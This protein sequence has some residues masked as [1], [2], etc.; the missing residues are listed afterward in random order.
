MKKQIS[1]D[2]LY[3]GVVVGCASYDSCSER[4]KLEVRN[5]FSFP[6]VKG[7]VAKWVTMSEEDRKRIEDPIFYMFCDVWGRCEYEFVVCPW[8]YNDED[9][10]DGCGV[11]VDTYRM[12]VEPNKDLLLDMVSRVTKSS[13]QAYL[14]EWRRAHRRTKC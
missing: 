1:L 2:D 4:G 5:L 11:K 10:I 12:Y 3:F 8:P 7:A 9:T 6:R 14:R 13:A